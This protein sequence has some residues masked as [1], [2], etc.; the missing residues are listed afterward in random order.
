M[1]YLVND[2]YDV[3]D[4][5]HIIAVRWLMAEKAA[6]IPASS[7]LNLFDIFDE[8]KVVL[9]LEEKRDSHNQ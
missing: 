9:Q 8:T 3:D 4:L 1:A 7:N 5:L 6:L 2:L